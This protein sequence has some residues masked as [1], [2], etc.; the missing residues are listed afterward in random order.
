[1]LHIAVDFSM[2]LLDYE[3]RKKV[4][5]FLN[6]IY[7]NSMIPTINKRTRVTRQSAAPIDHIL[8][9]C[10]LNFDFKTAIFKSGISGHI[11]F[12]FFLP[13]TNQF[14][15][16]EPIYIH[17]RI[18]NTNPI[19]MFCQKLHE[20]NWVEIKTSR[21]PNVCYKIFLKKFVPLYD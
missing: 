2:T 5:E 9:N 7:K 10:F 13:M 4:K 11:S 8:T 12:S 18:I 16:T 6:L 21:N 19:E 14:S 15:K 1:M 17:K 3:K 20:T